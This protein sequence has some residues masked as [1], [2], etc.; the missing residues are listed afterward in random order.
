MPFLAIDGVQIAE[1]DSEQAE[2]LKSLASDSAGF[3]A[4]PLETRPQELKTWEIARLGGGPLLR[5]GYSAGCQA[6][7]VL[8]FPRYGEGTTKV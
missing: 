8:F 3:L 2:Y 4:S 7:F 6:S 5:Y 1:I